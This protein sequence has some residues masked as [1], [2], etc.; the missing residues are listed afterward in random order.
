MTREEETL[1][2][3]QRQLAA[4]GPVLPGSLSEQ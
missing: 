2:R 4:L 3:I 1:Q